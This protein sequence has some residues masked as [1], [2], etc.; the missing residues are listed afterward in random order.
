[1][2]H[3]IKP[4]AMGAGVLMLA[5]CA[6]GTGDDEK[7]IDRPDFKSETGIFD[8]DALEALGRVTEPVVSPDGMKILFGIS[9][10]S[11]EENTSNRDLYV[12]DIDGTNQQRL[13]R[14]AKSEN[15]AVWIDGGKR[16]AFM[17]PVD[18]KPQLWVMNADGS[19]RAAVS[20]VEGGISGFKFSPDEKKVVMIGNVKYSRN[21]QDIYPDLPKATGRVIDDLIYM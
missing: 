18:G 12:V 8:I 7:I 14:T 10:E 6:A 13:T 5:S 3:L 17:Y 9:Y 11:V 21:A 19:N 4:I 20:D 15:N 16:I 2:Q 1:M